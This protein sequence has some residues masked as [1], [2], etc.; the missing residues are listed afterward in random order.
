[1]KLEAVNRHPDEHEEENTEPHHSD[2]SPTSG[3]TLRKLHGCFTSPGAEMREEN[4]RRGGQPEDTPV[5]RPDPACD[6][7]NEPDERQRVE[8]SRL[9]ES[10]VTSA[11]NGQPVKLSRS[12]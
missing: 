12:T 11:V 10:S 8:N 1:M 4:T 2:K 5:A 9:S 6:A 7:Q 3:D